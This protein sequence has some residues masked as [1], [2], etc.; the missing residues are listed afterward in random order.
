MAIKP[1]KLKSTK[2]IKREGAVFAMAN[3]GKQGPLFFGGSDGKVYQADVNAKEF[4]PQT[5]HAHRSYVTGLAL[6]KDVL[7][8]GG[9]D[10]KLV[11]WNVKTGKLIRSVDHAHSK[12][13]GA[14]TAAPDNSWVASI[15]DDMV[16]RIWNPQTGKPIRELR[17]HKQQTPQHYPS[18]LYAMAVTPDGRFLATGD[19]VGH[20]VVWDVKTGKSVTTLE[21]PENYTW[22][23]KQRRRSIGGIRS[24]T[25]SADGKQLAVGGVA[26]INNVDGLGGKALVHVY[27]WK[28]GKQLHRFAHDKHK[29]LVEHLQFSNDGKMVVGAGG[30]G[31]GFLL[32]MDLTTKKFSK[33]S[34]AKMHVHAFQVD[35]TAATLTAVGF[36][37]IALWSLKG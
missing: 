36:G 16:C 30:A 3:G 23:P 26:K 24:L 1:D 20:I 22:D 2:R 15:A 10:R 19:R 37:G 11:F 25:F 8:S 7:V 12:W 29:G 4:K 13:L 28:A 6:A 31:G 14:V 9:W 34:D 32:F 17:G 33:V 18:M 21:S 27:D 5:L 35:E